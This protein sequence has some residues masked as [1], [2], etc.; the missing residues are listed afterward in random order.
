MK[1]VEGVSI[2]LKLPPKLFF[3]LAIDREPSRCGRTINRV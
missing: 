2:L 1:F 3:S